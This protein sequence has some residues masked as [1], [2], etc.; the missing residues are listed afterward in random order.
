MVHAARQKYLDFLLQPDSNLRLFTGAKTINFEVV[1]V[2]LNMSCKE[3]ADVVMKCIRKFDP[4]VRV[5][6]TIYSKPGTKRQDHIGLRRE[7][8]RSLQCPE[9]FVAAGMKN[10]WEWEGVRW[11][12]NMKKG[13]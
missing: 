10:K 9:E 5:S 7:L 8:T 12:W 3:F 2:N 4:W 11:G 13:N 6:L 1:D